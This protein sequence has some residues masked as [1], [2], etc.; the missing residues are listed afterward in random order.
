MRRAT[1]EVP[2]ICPNAALVC[3]PV[4]KLKVNDEFGFEGLKW[5]NVL[6][7][8]ARN[9]SVFRSATLKLFDSDKSMFST[10][11]PYVKVGGV[12][13]IPRERMPGR[14]KLDAFNG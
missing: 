5:L 13:P 4:L 11:G 12:L 2:V 8:S 3:A 7:A 6:N 14:L 10:P 1:C 9:S